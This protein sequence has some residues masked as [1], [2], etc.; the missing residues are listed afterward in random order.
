MSDCSIIAIRIVRTSN[1]QASNGH[2]PNVPD[3][4]SPISAGF[5][6]PLLVITSRLTSNQVILFGDRTGYKRKNLILNQEYYILKL[7]A[8]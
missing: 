2:W 6:V 4:I 7:L 5:I 3:F 8:L 1:I